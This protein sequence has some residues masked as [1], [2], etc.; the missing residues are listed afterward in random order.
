[1]QTLTDG[2]IILSFFPL[3]IVAIALLEGVLGLA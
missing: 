2:Y 3:S 1:V